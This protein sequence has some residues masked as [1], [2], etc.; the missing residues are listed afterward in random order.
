ME[1]FD[2]G[3]L[4]NT[5]VNWLLTSG[6][7]IVLGL[8]VL[9]I[10]FKITNAIFNGIN[11]RLSKKDVDKT[12]RSV[13][14]SVLRKCVKVLLVVVYIGYLGFD[15]SSIAA[16]IASSAVAVGLALQG[17]LSNLAG[18]V[19]IVVLR[20]F[21]IGDF[22]QTNG[23]SGTVKKI[24]LFNTHLTTPDGKSV[25]IPNGKVAG[26]VIVNISDSKNRRLDLTFSIAYEN[27]FRKAKQIIRNEIEKSGLA[28]EEPAPYVNIS[29]HSGSSVDI[30]VRVWVRSEDYADMNAYLLEGVKIA[31]DKNNISIPYQQ[32]DIHMKKEIENLI[33]QED[34]SLVKKEVEIYQAKKE[35]TKTKLAERAE[36]EKHEHEEK[37]SLL[38][39]FDNISKVEE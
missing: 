34:D 2:W 16:V 21:K 33:Y 12:I 26:D 13:L 7:K 14:V 36:A 25:I 9:I 10:G 6:L 1:S 29:A 37:K 35:K 23:Q 4:L 22:I 24:E 28:L 19:I 30:A 38:K 27:D 32:V 5:I 11:K 17:A 3:A 20:P 15:T 18:G 31:F 8:I 39:R